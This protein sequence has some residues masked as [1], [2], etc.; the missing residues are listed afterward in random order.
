[1]FFEETEPE[2]IVLNQCFRNI[3]EQGFYNAIFNN[4]NFKALDEDGRNL[5]CGVIIG[6]YGFDGI[7]DFIETC[8]EERLQQL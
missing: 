6:D 1:M 8:V 7:S 4:P 3:K 5:V 2:Y